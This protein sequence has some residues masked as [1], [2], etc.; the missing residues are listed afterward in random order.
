MNILLER[1]FFTDETTIGNMYIDGK[2]LCFTLE[3]KDRKLEEGGIKIYGKTCIPRGKY[4]VTLDYSN[5]YSKIMPHIL[6][7]PQFE[8]IRIHPGNYAKDTEG[9]VIIGNTRRPDFVGDSRVAF[10]SL[11]SEMERA[12]TDGETMEITIS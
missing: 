7:V 5:K 10:A 3:D 8:G 4:L 11:M 2:W 9:C 1:K 6:N 12:V